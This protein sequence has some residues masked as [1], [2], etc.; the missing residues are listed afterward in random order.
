MTYPQLQASII[1]AQRLD[2][3]YEQLLHNA[4]HILLD[5]GI[6]GQSEV[7]KS[8]GMAQSKLSVLRPIL[9]AY[10]NI[11]LATSAEGMK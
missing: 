10:H 5:I 6:R 2:D 1:D 4:E 11:T 3:Y 9:I 8:I 7:A